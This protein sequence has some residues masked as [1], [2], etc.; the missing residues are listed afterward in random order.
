[1]PFYWIEG[2]S[3]SSHP[4]FAAIYY[5][6]VVAHGALVMFAIVFEWI[7]HGLSSPGYRRFACVLMIIA[8]LAVFVS[9][10][11]IIPLLLVHAILLSK[12][13]KA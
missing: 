1:L 10:F 2:D 12:P 6:F 11:A 9:A 3:L 7:G 13:R 5:Y 4:V 8:M